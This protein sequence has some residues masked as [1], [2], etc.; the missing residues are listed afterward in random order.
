[1]SSFTVF[2]RLIE[3]L[4]AVES[5]VRRMTVRQNNMFREGVVKEVDYE[6]GT[7]IITAHGIDSPP[8][9][10][11]E[12]AGDINEWTPPSVGQRVMLLSPDGDMAKSVMIKGGFTDDTPQP[13]NKGA[14]KRVVIGGTTITHTAEGLFIEANGTTFQFTGEGFVQVGG[15]QEHDEKNVGSTHIHGGVVPGAANTDVPA[16]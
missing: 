14:E 6:N 11:S 10:W 16:N 8:T 5:V 1:M 3:R 7:V 12:Q 9:S 4:E 2:D 15:K 13:H